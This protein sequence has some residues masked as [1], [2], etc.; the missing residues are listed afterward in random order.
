M[1]DPED[2]EDNPW[3][4]YR[5]L[6][7]NELERLNQNFEHLQKSVDAANVNIAMLKVKAGAWGA[8]AGLMTALT[9]VLIAKFI[10]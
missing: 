5:R 9:A 1:T 6:V 10:K 7:L 2:R 3:S 8:M 4:E